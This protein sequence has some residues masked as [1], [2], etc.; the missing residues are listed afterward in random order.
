MDR[1]IGIMLLVS[2]VASLMLSFFNPLKV[3][4]G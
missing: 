3:F 4:V 1:I 2:A